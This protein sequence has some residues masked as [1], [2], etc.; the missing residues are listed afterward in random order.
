MV[1]DT[2]HSGGGT[3]PGPGADG[4]QPW[5]S[6]AL[7]ARDL[8]PRVA[9]Q[10]VRSP[11]GPYGPSPARWP[12]EEAEGVIYHP[13]PPRAWGG[14]AVP[15]STATLDA[16]DLEH[17]VTA[18]VA[19][20]SLHNTQPWRFRL[21]PETRTVQI[22]A[23]VD[24]ELRHTDPTGRAVQLSVGCAVL[25]LR[26]AAAHLGCEPVTRLLPHPA[27]PDL[28]ATVRLAEATRRTATPDLYGPCGAGAAAASP[29]PTGHRP[30]NCSPNWPR[31]PTP[32]GLLRPFPDRGRPTGCCA[33]PGRPRTATGRTPTGP[34]RAAAGPV[35]RHARRWGCPRRLW[36]LRTPWTGS[37]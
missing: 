26:I 29:S 30:R 27:R 13:R 11:E 34:P 7:L 1:P 19:A 4:P 24:R 35:P 6:T 36:D 25:N 21:D 5:G 3:G 33:R 12:G 18:A 16:V 23:A 37:P 17:L 28:L 15:M 2:T 8:R 14:K 31:R 32:K 10:A 22:L 9:A 20:P